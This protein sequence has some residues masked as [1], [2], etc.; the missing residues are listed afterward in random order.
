MAV[1]VEMK[2]YQ[3]KQEVLLGNDIREVWEFFSN[4]QNL[5]LI[6]PSSLN[7]KFISGAE[8]GKIY[9]G[10]MIEY[11]VHPFLGIPWQWVTEITHVHDQEY[12]VD[13]QRFGPYRLWHHRH[14]FL[15]TE[16]GVLA[17]D[18]VHYGLYGGFIGEIMRELVVKRQL[19][20][21]FAYRLT[22]LKER[23]KV[24]A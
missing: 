23:F 13:E 14:A 12:F 9:P 16:K 18:H 6:T 1:Q 24:L 2:I 21:I 20:D 19:E 22:K 7:F 11:R 10:K 8:D 17:T 5:A 3:I 4:P 15:Q